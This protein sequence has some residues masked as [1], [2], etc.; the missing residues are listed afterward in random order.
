MLGDESDDSQN[1]GDNSQNGEGNDSQ[2]GEGND[3]L[4]EGDNAHEAHGGE[5][6]M[7]ELRVHPQRLAL[8]RNLLSVSD[9]N[10]R[11]AQC[12]E[13]IVKETRSFSILHIQQVVDILCSLFHYT[14]RLGKE[15]GC[16]FPM[17]AKLGELMDVSSL[18]SE[19]GREQLG[20]IIAQLNA[21]C[22]SCI[23]VF[24]RCVPG[25]REYFDIL[26]NVLYMAEENVA[27]AARSE[28]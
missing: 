6:E 24:A 27:A 21:A 3:S 2:N 7:T 22:K 23:L 28:A 20:A 8:V 18:P 19:A 14:L 13:M 1:E 25:D 11:D 12:V 10:W 26:E 15:N 5:I 4:N 16:S 9:E 17:D